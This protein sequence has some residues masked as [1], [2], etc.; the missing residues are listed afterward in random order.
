MAK[1]LK[2]CKKTGEACRDTCQTHQVDVT[3]IPV[4]LK[5]ALWQRPA[6][7]DDLRGILKCTSEK[8]V[9]FVVGDN[10]KGL[11]RLT[12]GNTRQG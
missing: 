10:G 2:L 3:A 5:G 6:T 12:D 4:K 11:Y 1:R 9:R 8:K 7:L